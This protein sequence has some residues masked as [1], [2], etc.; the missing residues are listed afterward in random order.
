MKLVS[1]KYERHVKLF[2]L[3]GICYIEKLNKVINP[4]NLLKNVINHHTRISV[5]ITPRRLFIV[6][7]VAIKSNSEFIAQVAFYRKFYK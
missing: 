4:I 7:N 1:Y 3:A 2:V 5:A 6:T